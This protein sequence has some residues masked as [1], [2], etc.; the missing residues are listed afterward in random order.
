MKSNKL[1]AEVTIL[2]SQ[3]VYGNSFIPLNRLVFEGNERQY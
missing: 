2:Y 3:S 1:L